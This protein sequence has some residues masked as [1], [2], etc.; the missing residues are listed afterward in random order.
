MDIRMLNEQKPWS[1]RDILDFTNYDR[2]TRVEI[3][4]LYLRLDEIRQEADNFLHGQCHLFAIALHRLTGLPLA[5]AI[6]IDLYNE[7]HT[8]LLHAYVELNDEM[9]IDVSG[10]RTRKSMLADFDH[11]DP[12]FTYFIEKEL[13]QWG[14]GKKYID[15]EAKLSLQK[16]YV[17]ALDI[18]SLE[19]QIEILKKIK[20]ISDFLQN[21]NAK[22]AMAQLSF[23]FDGELPASL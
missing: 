16:A 9:I 5:G 18:R 20:S 14:E 23:T 7:S 13:L 10:V 3:L 21:E 15:E 1:S 8:S 19:M 22:G 6:D 11:V 12:D 2:R 4:D 17:V